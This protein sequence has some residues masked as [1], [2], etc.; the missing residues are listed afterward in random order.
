MPVQAVVF[1]VGGVLCPS[2]VDEFDKVDTEYRLPA[3]TVQSLFRG[4]SLFAQCEVGQLRVDTFFAACSAAIL[5]DHGVDVPPERL[6]EM[7]SACMGD[8]VR[9]EMLALVAE[10]RAAGYQIGLLT[11][12]F[13]ERRPWLHAIFPEGTVDVFAD[14]S[15]LGMRKPDPAIYDRLLQMLGREPHEVAFI[16]DFAEN[17]VPARES[18]IVDILFASPGQVR[19]ELAAAGVRIDS[20]TRAVEVA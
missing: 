13:A 6:D 11:N 10:V 20:G 5:D 9:P 1:D 19:T 14:S 4:G 17:L 3:G 2:P 8:S 18:G 15:E 16:D 12:I 7:L